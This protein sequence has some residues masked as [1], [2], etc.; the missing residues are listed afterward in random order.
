[1]VVDQRSK[2]ELHR[3]RTR[4]GSQRRVRCVAILCTVVQLPFAAL[5]QTAEP[6]SEIHLK[7]RGRYEQ[8]ARAYSEARYED[9][10]THFE[11]AYALEPAGALL[12]NIAQA[13]RLRTPANCQSALRHYELYLAAE[14]RAPERAEVEGNMERMRQCLAEA[15][16]VP[17]APRPQPQP[18]ATAP[19]TSP[20]VIPSYTPVWIGA[21][22]AFVFVGG[23]VLYAVARSRFNELQSECRPCSDDTIDRWQTITNVSYVSMALGSLTA[24]TALAW[25]SWRGYR[26]DERPETVA[27]TFVAAPSAW[28]SGRNIGLVWQG[29]F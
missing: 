18:A 24:A 13:N 8:G 9:A 12:L 25:W 2:T 20:A 16:R 6:S 7:A 19:A 1:M 22:G 28:V 29:Q 17:E 11:A 10:I 3:N 5:A 15:S 27:S 23:G 4:K 21:A 14:P 26:S